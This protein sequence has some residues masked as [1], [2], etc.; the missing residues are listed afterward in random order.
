MTPATDSTRNMTALIHSTTCSTRRCSRGIS[1]TS[2]QSSIDRSGG[3]S[4]GGRPAAGHEIQ[5]MPAKTVVLEGLAATAGGAGG[6][7]ARR[8]F[9]LVPRLGAADLG[10]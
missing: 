3:A 6:C 5:T 7:G 2:Q 8:L 10:E 1:R 9:R 4:A